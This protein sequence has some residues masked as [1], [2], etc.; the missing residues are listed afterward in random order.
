MGERA[1]SLEGLTLV[2]DF[3]MSSAIAVAAMR[4]VAV[5]VSDFSSS[6]PSRFRIATSASADSDTPQRKANALKRIFSTAEGRAVMD[7]VTPWQPVWPRLTRDDLLHNADT[8]LSCHKINFNSD[9][10]GAHRRHYRRRSIEKC[11][12][13]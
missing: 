4:S 7:G 3:S 11:E 6:G 5:G 1:Q 9:K 8:S 10:G 2:V 12:G 13:L